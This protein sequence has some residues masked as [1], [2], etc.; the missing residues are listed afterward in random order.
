[1]S[2]AIAGECELVIGVMTP[3][4]TK[5]RVQWR[6]NYCLRHRVQNDRHDMAG[7]CSHAANL[8]SVCCRTPSL[9]AYL[10]FWLPVLGEIY[11]IHTFMHTP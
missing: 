5:W 11:D 2:G 1:M 8:L 10:V 9:L 4:R 3:S 6:R 7:T